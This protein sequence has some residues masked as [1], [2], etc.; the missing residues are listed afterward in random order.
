METILITGGT[1]LIGT[2]LSELFINRGYKVIV[3]TRSQKP[4][5]GNISYA[6]WDI[7]KSIIDK[8]VIAGADHII[9]LAGAGVADKRWTRKRK[10]E[11]L[12]SRVLSAKL[13]VKS[14]NETENKVQTVVSASGIG[15]YGADT[16]GSK[17]AFVESDPPDTD[18][19]GETCRLWEESIQPVTV[20]G[21]RLVIFRTGIVLSNA[22][23]AFVEFKKP[24]KAGIAAILGNGNQA[25]SWIH[26]DDICRLYLAAIENKNLYGVYNAV[27]PE[28]VT[29]K[30]LTIKLAKARKKPF[31]PVHVPEFALKIV[32]GEMSIEV[33]KST[34]VDASKIR[35]SG[36]NFLFPGLDAALNE[37]IGW[38]KI[39]PYVCRGKC[40]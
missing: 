21:K 12:N 24:L 28:H 30:E 20:M 17:R 15:W 26:I 35:D 25:V 31:I 39:P 13:L 11:I 37:L 22:G 19:L 23:G 29:N 14:L 1:G 16:K 9:H 6:L 5:K 36:F 2:A 27:T 34:T 33:L 40:L 10:S 3:L 32:L 8:N 38:V 18:F 4:P 7:N